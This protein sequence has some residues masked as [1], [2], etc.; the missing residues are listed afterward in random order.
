MVPA[1][2]ASCVFSRSLRIWPLMSGWVYSQDREIPAAWATPANVT[3]VPA[4]SSSRSAWTAFARVSWCRR[5]AASES[6][7]G[8]TGGCL[9]FLAAAGFESSDD[10]VEV[11]GDLPVHLGKAGMPVRLGGGDDLQGLLPLGMMLREKLGGLE[12]HRASQ[13]TVRMRAGLDDRELAVPVRERLGGPG[14]LLFGPGGLGEGPGGVE[15]DGLSAG[16]DL[17]GGFPVPADGGVAQPGVMRRHFGSLVIE[18]L[19]H[20]MLGDVTVDEGRSQRVAELVR[21]D[22]DRGAVMAADVAGRQPAAEPAAV[23]VAVRRHRA[24][25]VPGGAGE[26]DRGPAGPAAGVPLPL[27]PDPVDDF[28]IDGTRA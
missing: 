10:A 7:S 3:G 27:P 9:H 2:P 25:A 26:Q 24:V 18:D 19:L 11:G 14:E 1:E 4:R 5:A 21:G 28:V 13:T 15:A 22:P 20:D 6:G 23:G 12:E 17:A 8:R 16:V